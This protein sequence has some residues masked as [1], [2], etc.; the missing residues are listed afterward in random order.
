M[1][2][3]NPKS[4]IAYLRSDFQKIVITLRGENEKYLC[5]SSPITYNPEK[6]TI[7]LTGLPNP[8]IKKAVA[9]LQSLLDRFSIRLGAKYLTSYSGVESEASTSRAYALDPSS[10]RTNSN[11]E[12]ARIFPIRVKENRLLVGLWFKCI[13]PA[14]P[15]ILTPTLGGTYSA[16]LVSRGQVEI[17][18]HPCIQIE[19]PHVPAL[20]AQKIIED[21]LRDICDK[22]GH[23]PIWILFAQGSVRDLKGREEEGNDDAEEVADHQRRRFYLVRPYPKPGMGASLGLL[24]SKKVVATLGGYVLID[25]D[26]YMLTSSHF[27]DKSQE[28][29]NMDIDDDDD[30][31]TLTSPSRYDLKQME[32]ALKQTKRDLNSAINSLAQKTYGDR[33]IPEENL[34][35]Q[36]VTPDLHEAK[37]KSDDVTKLLDQV[38]RP[39]HEYI[40]GT[41]DMRSSETRT[42]SMPRH[43][44]GILRLENNMTKLTHYMDWS[45]CKLKSQTGENRHKYRSNEDAMADRYVEEENHAI[46][47]GDICYETCD[48]DSGIAIH[49]VGQG[50]DHRSG[51]VNIPM[52]VSRHSFV[53]HEWAIMSSEGHQIPYTQV[54]GDSGAW[55]I[56]QH[57]NK[58]MGQVQAH[59]NGQVL[60]TPIDVIF[61]DLGKRCGVEVS[62]PPCSPDP[63]QF[64]NP[65]LARDLC[66]IPDTPPVRP[67]RFLL[68]SSELSAPCPDK[69]LVGTALSTTGPLESPSEIAS[70]GDNNNTRGQVSS[71]LPCNSPSSLPDLTDSTQSPLTML[72]SPESPRSSEGTKSPNGQAETVILPSKSLPTT[73]GRWT[74]SEVPYLA[75]DEQDGG[76]TLEFASPALKF[77]PYF[78]SRVSAIARTP[79]WPVDGRKKIT[80]VVRGSGFSQHQ[81]SKDHDAAT[82]ARSVLNMSAWLAR[83]NGMCAR[84]GNP[85]LG[86]LRLT[87]RFRGY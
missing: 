60:F 33:D 70:P 85:G 38:T 57:G 43:L 30:S 14:L 79:T 58:L 24:C 22:E 1:I 50:S 49:Y 74:E 51:V 67:Y 7:T 81:S 69:Q 59:S 8:A 47:P 87:M 68:K 42:V 40:V 45:L 29:A 15:E 11:S 39:P 6:E 27:V 86:L 16:S 10:A 76:Q 73:V 20:A 56:R 48:A 72:E 46:Q 17:R 4:H 9:S 3:L 77:K 21:S 63:G 65:S 80:K 62:L 53:T 23:Q 19:S 75:L 54:A 2:T 83:R 64:S 25:G 41:F 35:D 44:A 71:S 61:V 34:S 78:L 26:K 32:D 37:E 82:L 13:L 5:A 12:R 66:A 36:R 52:L 18:A 28:R 55:V 84:N 31:G